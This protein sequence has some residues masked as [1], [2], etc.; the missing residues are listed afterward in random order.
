MRDAS[1]RE[2]LC[3]VGCVPEKVFHELRAA[4][5]FARPAAPAKAGPG[6]EL[7]LES[8]SPLFESRE[9]RGVDEAPIPLQEAASDWRRAERTGT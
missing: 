9:R 3:A 2:G 1:R 8:T 5:S 6:I 4:G 7:L